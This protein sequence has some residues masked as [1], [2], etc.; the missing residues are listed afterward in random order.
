MKAF[1]AEMDPH[2][3]AVLYRNIKKYFLSHCFI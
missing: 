3:S 2:L 1:C